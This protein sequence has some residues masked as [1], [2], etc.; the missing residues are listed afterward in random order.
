MTGKEEDGRRH[1]IRKPLCFRTGTALHGS[2]QLSQAGSAQAGQG[3]GSA[4][5][6]VPG[7]PA[8][9]RDAGPE[10][11]DS[12]GRARD[13]A[14]LAVATTTDVYMQELPEGVRATVDSIHRELQGTMKK[15]AARA[16]CGRQPSLQMRRW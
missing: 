15:L 13:D 2:E 8:H 9:D 11:G 6:D 4:E 16:S 10:E 5:A 12:E 7:H 14:A 3:T 1:P